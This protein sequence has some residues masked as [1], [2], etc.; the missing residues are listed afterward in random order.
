MYR[1]HG[2]GFQLLSDNQAKLLQLHTL[3]KVMEVTSYV[4]HS[5]WAVKNIARQFQA[6]TS[7]P[8]L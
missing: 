3:Y 4:S 5:Q 1:L 6:L 2:V 7:W 8:H